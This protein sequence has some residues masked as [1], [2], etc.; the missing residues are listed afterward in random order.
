MVALKK[1]SQ[2][3]VRRI[4]PMS[5]SVAGGRRSFMIN[6]APR[7]DF[8]WKCCQS[9]SLHPRSWCGISCPDERADVTDVRRFRDGFMSSLCLLVA[10]FV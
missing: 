9:L 8:S 1:K 2:R 10:V 6:G 3:K 5:F 4:D 7:R